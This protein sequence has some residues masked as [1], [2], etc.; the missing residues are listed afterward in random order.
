VQFK[1]CRKKMWKLTKMIS[2]DT[3][4]EA[5]PPIRVDVFHQEWLDSSVSGLRSHLNDKGV[6]ASEKLSRIFYYEEGMEGP[7]VRTQGVMI[8]DDTTQEAW[9]PTRMDVFH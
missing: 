9:P 5:W 3:A 8:S 6:S 2:D 7:S 4:Q 1:D